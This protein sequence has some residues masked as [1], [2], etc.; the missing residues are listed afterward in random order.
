LPPHVNHCYNEHLASKTQ[1][2]SVGNLIQATPE[3]K[4]E[5]LKTLKVAWG[6]YWLV[7]VGVLVMISSLS[8]WMLL[9]PVAA[10]LWLAIT[11]GATAAATGSSPIV[12][13]AGTFFLG[14]LGTLFLPW[15]QLHR[16]R[17]SV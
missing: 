14:P 15:Y 6:V 17:A 9:A 3:K 16:L 11:V 2:A 8:A 7:Y 10:A 1:E 13:G 12:W 5:L 4:R